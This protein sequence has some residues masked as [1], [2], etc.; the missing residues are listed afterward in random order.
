MVRRLVSVF[1][2]DCIFYLW[3]SQFCMRNLIW[4]VARFNSS[5]SLSITVY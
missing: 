2:D 1:Y 3:Q 4:S 5:F